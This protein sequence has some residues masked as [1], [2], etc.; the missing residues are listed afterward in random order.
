MLTS[1]VWLFGFGWFILVAN[2]FEFSTT[3]ATLGM[4]WVATST[5]V[6]KA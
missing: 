3:K 5:G 4:S 1:T 6:E 2:R